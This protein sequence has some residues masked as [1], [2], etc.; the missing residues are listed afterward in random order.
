MSVRAAR[1]R[2]AVTRWVV[3]ERL[4]GATLLEV[5]PETGRTHQIRVHLASIG[6]AVVGDATYGGRRKGGSG[7]ASQVLATCA[8]QALHA[9]RLAFAHPVTGDPLV[10]EAPLPRI[11]APSSRRC[12]RWREHTEITHKTP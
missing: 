5:R 8:R 4:P 3:R 7:D 9:A 10:L 2:A 6:H 1:G 12:A 11:S